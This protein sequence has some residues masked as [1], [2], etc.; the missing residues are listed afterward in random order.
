MFWLLVDDKHKV[1]PLL[2]A[3]GDVVRY[4]VEDNV[5][6]IQGYVKRRV[7]DVFYLYPD[8]KRVLVLQLC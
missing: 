8:T 3:R 5:P 2:D 4:A 6:N 1:H 7:K